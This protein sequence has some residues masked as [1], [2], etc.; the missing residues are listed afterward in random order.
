MEKIF[1]LLHCF[2]H[3]GIFFIYSVCCLKTLKRLTCFACKT[4]EQTLSIYHG[5]FPFHTHRHSFTSS[6][7]FFLLSKKNVYKFLPVLMENCFTVAFLFCHS[8]ECDIKMMMMMSFSSFPTVLSYS[9]H[10]KKIFHSYCIHF[11]LE[12]SIRTLHE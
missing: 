8:L 6:F 1:L 5:N 3:K 11:S 12:K 2:M 10:K 7:S 4:L 9:T